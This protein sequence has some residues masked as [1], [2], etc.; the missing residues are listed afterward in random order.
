MAPGCPPDFP[1]VVFEGVGNPVQ[2]PASCAACVCS[3]PTV[4]CMLA[5]LA[6]YGGANCAGG[7][8]ALVQPTANNAC[9]DINASAGTDSYRAGPPT[10][11]V[12][13]CTAS[14]GAANVPPAQ[15]GSFGRLCG[16]TLSDAGCGAQGEVCVPNAVASPFEGKVCVWRLGDQSCPAA[17]PH[18][19]IFSDTLDDTR[20]CSACGCGNAAAT[21]TATTTV[22]SDDACATALATVPNNNSCVTATVGQ[23]IT[24]A[25]TTIGS[26]PASGGNPTGDVD[27]GPNRL[28]VC[29]AQ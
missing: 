5:N 18:E 2:Q 3:A 11:S 13:A 4:S 24:V 8:N 17:Y 20:G 1:D 15:A 14:G 19:H 27:L 7:A 22:Y 9:Q 10:V 26:C 21:C 23:S 25:R 16:A 6:T 12:S 28:T 29:C